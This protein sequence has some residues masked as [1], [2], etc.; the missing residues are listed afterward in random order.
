ETERD[1]V[2]DRRRHARRALRGNLGRALLHWLPEGPRRPPDGAV[3]PDGV[4]SI[5][6]PL[7]RPVAGSR[8]GRAV[9]IG[10]L[11]TVSPECYAC[12]EAAAMANDLYGGLDPRN[13]PAYTVP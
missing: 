7:T 2:H 10:V 11:P 6:E 8:P 4:A 9:P 12:S 5:A 3:E 1:R 13:V